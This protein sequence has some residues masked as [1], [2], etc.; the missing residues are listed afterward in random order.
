MKMKTKQKKILPIIFLMSILVI[1]SFIIGFSLGDSSK[2]NTLL[3][4]IM[5]SDINLMEISA[6]GLMA[7]QYYA[8]A[9]FAY[10][11]GDYNSVERECRMAREYYFKESQGYKKVKAE[12]KATEIEDRLII[13]YIE[14]L[15]DLIELTNN[16]FEACEHFESAVRY[17][18]IYYNT[19]VPYNDM[20]FDMGGEE[21]N[22]MNE[23]IRS[24]DKVVERY[25]N[26]LA[27]YKV[28]LELRK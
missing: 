9:G 12:L 28:E 6:D 18:D 2:E 10:E 11:K 24:H 19:D 17:Y 8:E 26:L 23:K 21:I 15:E 4:T 16:M 7:E 27:E 13:L 5:I 3:K 1:L 25:N 20:S 14:M 22:M